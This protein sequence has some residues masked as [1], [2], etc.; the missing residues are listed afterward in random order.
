MRT[1]F[2]VMRTYI[3]VDYVRPDCLPVISLY[4]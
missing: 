3:V 4:K 1:A 2:V